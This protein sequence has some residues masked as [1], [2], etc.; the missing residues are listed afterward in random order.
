MS[1]VEKIITLEKETHKVSQVWRRFNES[2]TVTNKHDKF[3]Q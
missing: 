2:G 1:L 3:L